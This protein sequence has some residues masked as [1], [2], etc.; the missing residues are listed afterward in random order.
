MRVTGWPRCSHTGLVSLLSRGVPRLP[1]TA[2]ALGGSEMGTR[3]DRQECRVPKL[4]EAGVSADTGH[5]CW[6]NTEVRLIDKNCHNKWPLWGPTGGQQPR[7]VTFQ[8]WNHLLQGRNWCSLLRD[9]VRN[10]EVRNRFGVVNSQSRPWVCPFT[11]G[12]LS[13]P[14]KYKEGDV[15]L[16]DTHLSCKARMQPWLG[17]TLGPEKH[18]AGPC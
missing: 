5:L 1:R 7:L 15:F 16:P 18:R 6:A 4:K 2:E 13:F 14:P 3:G 17:K 8:G 12:R 10:P 9:C 11:C